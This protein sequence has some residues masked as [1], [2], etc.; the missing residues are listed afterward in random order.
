MSVQCNII[1][2]IGRLQDIITFVIVTCR[3]LKIFKKLLN[4][5]ILTHK[6]HNTQRQSL[7]YFTEVAV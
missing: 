2:V 3:Q 1:G 6:E 5:E 4:L 7:R